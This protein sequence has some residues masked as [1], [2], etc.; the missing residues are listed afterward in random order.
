MNVSGLVQSSVVLQPVGREEPLSTFHAAERLL[1][2]G[3]PR[4]DPLVV[5]DASLR[6]EL[7]PADRADERSDAGVTAEMVHQWPALFEQPT[8]LRAAEALLVRVGLEVGRQ[9]TGGDVETSAD[10]TAVTRCSVTQLMHLNTSHTHNTNIE[11]ISA[12]NSIQYTAYI[13]QSHHFPSLPAIFSCIHRKT[14]GMV[15]QLQ[16][17]RMHIPVPHAYIQSGSKILSWGFPKRTGIS[18]PNFT[19][20][21]DVSICTGLQIFIQL[22]ATVTKYLMKL[23]AEYYWLWFFPD[24]VCIF[25]HWAKQDTASALGS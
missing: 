17:V 20:L 2:S 23:C 9:S 10:R 6:D 1:I 15:S 3:G 22:S 24:T 4:V 25:V 13:Q 21:L 14:G 7:F 16:N 8:A 12:N 5:A 11:V 18:S 19:R